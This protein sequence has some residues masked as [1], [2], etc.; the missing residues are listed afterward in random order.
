[1]EHSLFYYM[2]NSRVLLLASATLGCLLEGGLEKSEG[3]EKSQNV[4]MLRVGI[5][6]R[7]SGNSQKCY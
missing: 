3:L 1:M 4:S 7:G 2:S 5:N 6:G